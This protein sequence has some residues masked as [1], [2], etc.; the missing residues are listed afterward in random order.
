MT[1]ALADY[2]EHI[3]VVTGIELGDDVEAARNDMTFG[4]LIDF[5]EFVGEF[6]NIC[7]G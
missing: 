3:E 5:A 2:V 1:C 4:D 6:F 7:A